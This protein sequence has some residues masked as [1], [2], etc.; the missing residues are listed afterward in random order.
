MQIV[1][2]LYLYA[3]SFVSLET[4][5]WGTIV[6]ARSSLANQTGGSTL[7]LARSLSLILI[8]APVFLFHWRLVQRASQA[9]VEERSSWLR[10]VFLF[11]MLV[12]TLIPVAQ[13]ALALINRGLL[14]AFRLDAVSRC[15]ATARR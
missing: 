3:L 9:D 11:G 6:L 5:L 13:N 8:G 10:A 7:Q 12:A 4:V 2:R 15:W 1:R 14:I